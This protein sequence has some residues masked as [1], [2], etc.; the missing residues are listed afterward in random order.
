MDV[1]LTIF[2]FDPAMD[3]IP[4]Y[5]S[6]SLPWTEGLTLL[7]AIRQIYRD[8]DR[9]LAFRNYFCARG[10]CSGCRVTVNGAVKK[11]CHVVLR[12]NAEYT[13][14]PLQ[15]YPVIRDLVVDFGIGRVC[16][17]NDGQIELR[18]GTVIARVGAHV[19]ANS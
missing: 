8:A 7:A 15:G 19:R 10:L 2:R 1:R 17:G 13:V 3:A 6:Y 18:Q 9:T 14:E 16:G 11:A 4:Y 5:R 12:P